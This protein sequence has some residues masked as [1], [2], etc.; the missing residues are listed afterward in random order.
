MVLASGHLGSTGSPSA[1][2]EACRVAKWRVDLGAQLKSARC[3]EYLRQFH[4]QLVPFAKT[5]PVKALTEYAEG[6]AL[7]QAARLS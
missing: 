4:R 3:A 6:H 1:V 5:A 2:E 7:W